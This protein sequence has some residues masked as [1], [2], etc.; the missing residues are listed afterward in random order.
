MIT[1]LP[2]SQ[3]CPLRRTPICRSFFK[4][5]CQ[6][7]YFKNMFV[8]MSVTTVFLHVIP[9]VSRAIAK[10]DIFKMSKNRVQN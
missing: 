2:F 6:V 1:L 5:Q 10:M 8:S 3:K 9:K 7:F 4:S